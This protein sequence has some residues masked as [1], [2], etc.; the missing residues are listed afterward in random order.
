MKTFHLRRCARPT[1]SN[2]LPTYASVRRPSRAL[3]LERFAR[4]FEILSG[5]AAGGTGTKPQIGR[6]RL[7]AGAVRPGKL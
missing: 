4:F 7:E 2:V 3:H 5:N 1:Y 6:V